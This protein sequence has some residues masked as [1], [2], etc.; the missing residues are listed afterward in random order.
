LRWLWISSRRAEKRKK[1][2]GEGE[3]AGIDR[4]RKGI[5]VRSHELLLIYR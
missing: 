5:T 4:V 3:K 2:E 1:E